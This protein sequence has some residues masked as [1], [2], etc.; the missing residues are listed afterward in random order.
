RGSDFVF[1]RDSTPYTAWSFTGFLTAVKSFWSTSSLSDDLVSTLKKRYTT[2][3]K[4]ISGNKKEVKEKRRMADFLIKQGGVVPRMPSAATQPGRVSFLP[5]KTDPAIKE[6]LESI[7]L[8][9]K[10]ALKEVSSKRKSEI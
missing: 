1:R 10:L 6:I 3:L 5:V 2:Y 8:D 4:D 7:I 9:E